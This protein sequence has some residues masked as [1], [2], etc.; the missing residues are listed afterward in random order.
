MALTTKRFVVS[1][2]NS[3]IGGQMLVIEGGLLA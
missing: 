1:E 2:E 3:H